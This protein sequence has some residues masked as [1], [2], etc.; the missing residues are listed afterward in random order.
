MVPQL[1]ICS[2]EGLKLF[3][4]RL[5][6]SQVLQ[7]FV[8]YVLTVVAARG[9]WIP[10]VTH[11]EGNRVHQLFVYLPVKLYLVIPQTGNLTELLILVF[12]G[13]PIKLV[14]VF[15]SQKAVNKVWANSEN[16][17]SKICAAEFMGSG[18][19]V[20]LILANGHFSKEQTRTLKDKALPDHLK[21]SFSKN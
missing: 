14:S 16:S 1:L 11:H 19:D 3:L 21:P 4:R 17:T 15:A 13:E 9:E 18:I 12:V 2:L 5:W 10:L 7:A 6:T 20:F 8:D